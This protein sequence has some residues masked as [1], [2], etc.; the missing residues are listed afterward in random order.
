M[1]LI[2]SMFYDKIN[3][4]ENLLE[5]FDIF[6]QSDVL[7]TVLKYILIYLTIRNIASIFPQ[8]TSN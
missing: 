7:L 4:V 2:K 5:K 3:K 8:Y 6:V 1:F